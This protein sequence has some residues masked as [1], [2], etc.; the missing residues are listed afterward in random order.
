MLAAFAEAAR[1]LGRDDY[2]RAAEANAAFLLG[3]LRDE[4][5]RLLRTWKDDGDGQAVR[6]RRHRQAQRLPR[7][8]RRPR[9]RAPAAL[10]DDLRRALVRRRARARRR[11]AR[12][13]RRRRRRLLRHERR[14]RGA[15][16][17]PA[18][19]GGQR[20]PLGRRHGDARAR[21]ARRLHRR[22][23]L[24]RGGRGGA[25]SAWPR[26]RRRCR[27]ASPSGSSPSTSTWRRRSRWRSSARSRE[28]ARGTAR[29]GALGVP[30]ARGRGGRALGWRPG[31]AGSRRGPRRRAAP[32]RAQAGRRQSRSLRLPSLRLR[33][34]GHG[35][36][37]PRR[38][39]RPASASTHRQAQPP[40][41]A[42]SRSRSA[43]A[44]CR[45]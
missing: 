36:G 19:R 28:A 3:E 6:A 41:R 32:R 31:P 16:A 30:A 1:V 4:R 40:N 24:R 29:R 12:A 35:R 8:L 2:R 9:A 34:A 5:G 39:L 33:R 21:A 22:R 27:W 13:L 38:A 45:S 25:R 7:G 17:P 23:P 11:D 26:T 42:A 44:F 18:Q 37:R 14:P 20:H 10:P 15:A 43:T